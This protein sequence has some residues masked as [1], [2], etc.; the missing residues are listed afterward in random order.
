MNVLT[1]GRGLNPRAIVTAAVLL[2]SPAASMAGSGLSLVVG[3]ETM[4]VPQDQIL[5]VT[6]RVDDPPGVAI[7]LDAV[8]ARELADLT[9]RHVFAD[10]AIIAGDEEIVRVTIMAP[11]PDGAI[12]LTF[13]TPEKAEKTAERL[14]PAPR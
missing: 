4:R 3:D 13:D 9:N 8:A 11:V 6:R 12:L 14:A 7:L 2:L 10:M 5:S 1:N